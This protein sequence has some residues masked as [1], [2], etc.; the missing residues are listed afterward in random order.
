MRRGL[1]LINVG[2]PEA[3]TPKAV[4]RYLKRFLDDHRLID[5][6]AI[7]RKP[8]VHGII[9]PRR[10]AESAAK[11]ATI[12]GEEGS[13]LTVYTEALTQAMQN[14]LGDDFIVRCAYAVSDPSIAMGLDALI[15]EQ[16][17]EL[18]LAPLF[19]QNASAT[20]GACL[21]Q[22]FG[23][24]RQA[25]VIP[26]VRVL[27]PFYNHPA[28]LDAVANHRRA[29]I[30]DAERVIFSFH[31]LPERHVQK[32]RHGSACEADG[33]KCCAASQNNSA[34]CYRAQSEISAREL[35]KRL[36]LRPDQWMVSF[37][38]RLGNQ[39]WLEPSTARCI[40][41]LGQN[42]CG[43][44]AVLCPSFVADCLETLEEIAD[45]AK[46][47]F[48]RA[49][50]G[51][52]TYVPALNAEPIWVDALAQMLTSLEPVSSHCPKSF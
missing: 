25:W 34:T 4:K 28:W 8:L 40:E 30:G 23:H 19:P 50:G 42:G 11:Y 27:P 3:P 52:F 41:V 36:G 18:I 13:P 32:A 9:A 48:T 22:A 6:P 33:K 49:G 10:A 15:D 47:V 31:G 46:S 17:D 44:L 43:N 45:E 12:W 5:L 39:R 1:L 7:F 21:D 29:A 51:H 38:S 20:T 26:P 35:A 37:Q 16:V 14:R 2:S 24:L